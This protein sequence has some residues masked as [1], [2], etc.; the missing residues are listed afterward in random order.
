M[1]CGNFLIKSKRKKNISK[2]LRRNNSETLV[3]V[4]V[5][6]RTSICCQS[7]KLTNADA[8]TGE[9]NMDASQCKITSN[10]T[11]S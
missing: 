3:V 11:S 9:Y 8:S 1:F 6:C 5:Q 2:D 7:G 10:N 4:M